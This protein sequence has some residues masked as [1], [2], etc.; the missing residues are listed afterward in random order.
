MN[1][2]VE[3]IFAEE[4]EK[5]EEQRLLVS[6]ILDET[7]SMLSCKEATISGFN[8]YIETLKQRR[9]TLRM[10]L[11]KFNSSRIEKTYE[12]KPI[13]EVEPLNADTYQPDDT[14]PLYDAIGQT[15]RGINN[16]S[17]VL[18]IIM[19]DGL[20]NASREYKREDI[21]K[22]IKEKEDEGWS[23]VFLG[24]NQDSWATGQALGFAAGNVADYC[25]S[26]FGM[27]N[28]F[29]VLA[30]NTMCYSAQT[31]NYFSGDDRKLMTKEDPDED[32]R[33]KE[34]D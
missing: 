25:E 19:T 8:E 7:G 18:C 23:F 31:K 4:Q 24:A 20:E 15:I 21:F 14:T 17:N 9:G 13:G 6:F 1:N 30:N 2:R 26:G 34:K 12:D 3:R 10:T 32:F 16:R 11:T 5:P 22:M 28:T 33:G 29:N 27:S